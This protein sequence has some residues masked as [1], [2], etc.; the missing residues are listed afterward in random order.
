MAIEM[1]EATVKTKP[2]EAMFLLS[3][4]VAA[5]LSGAIEHIRGI[6]DRSGATVVAMRKWDERRL[7][8]EI[9]KQK[10]GFYL[11][12]YFTGT[13]DIAG[14]IE[15]ECNLSERIMRV[16]ITTADHLTDE[17]IA[18]HD[19]RDTLFAEAKMRSE[20]SPDA[21]ES[22]GTGARLGAPEPER[23]PGEEEASAGEGA[24]GDESDGGSDDEGGD[25]EAAER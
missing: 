17:E 1:P 15:A 22:R 13:G 25:G 3:Q 5:D 24:Q 2:Y 8:Y 19:D 12:V 11:L 18:H 6:L 7:A 23:T 4:A 9:D 14:R 21:E 10:R 16:L 20:R